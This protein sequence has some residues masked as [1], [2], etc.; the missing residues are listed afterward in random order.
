[1]FSI[2]III[3]HGLCLLLKEDQVNSRKCPFAENHVLFHH[4]GT[5]I[6]NN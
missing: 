3:S 1:M 4:S 6:H 5:I 2:L